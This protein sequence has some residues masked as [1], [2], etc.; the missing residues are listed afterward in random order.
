M[1]HAARLEIMV[2][3]RLTSIQSDSAIINIPEIGPI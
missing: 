3:E 2:E 1:Q